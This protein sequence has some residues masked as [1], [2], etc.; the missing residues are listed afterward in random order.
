MVDPYKN[1]VSMQ[2]AVM[3]GWVNSARHVFECWRHCLDVQQSFLHD[4]HRR[5]S[6]VISEGPSLTDKYGKRS[7]D[8]DPERDV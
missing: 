2:T 6:V 7:H 8:I 1:L 3:E 5:C 4:S